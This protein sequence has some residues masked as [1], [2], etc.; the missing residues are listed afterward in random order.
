[1]HYQPGMCTFA[2]ANVRGV[3]AQQHN[4]AFA[5]FTKFLAEHPVD[6]IIEIGTAAGGLALWLRVTSKLPVV[7]YDIAEFALHAKLREMGVDTRT[8]DVFNPEHQAELSALIRAPGRVL[9]LC[10][11]G[12]KIREFN[13]FSDDLK[14]GDYIMA[15]DYCE[16]RETYFSKMQKVWPWWEIDKSAISAAMARNKLTEIMPESKDA[17]LFTARCDR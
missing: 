15:H 10:D 7:T 16:D 4:D 14:P 11:G 8:K 9:L 12:N 5:F 17:V 3:T 1:M 13:T 2:C 6:R